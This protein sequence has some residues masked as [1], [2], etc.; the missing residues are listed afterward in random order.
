MAGPNPAIA[1][2]APPLG[3]ATAPLSPIGPRPA[4]GRG[5]NLKCRTVG[6]GSRRVPRLARDDMAGCG[7]V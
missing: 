7:R 6:P 4:L 3:P 1:C 2:G 5:D